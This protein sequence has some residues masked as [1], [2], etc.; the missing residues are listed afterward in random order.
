MSRA[1]S[2]N[3]LRHNK[4]GDMISEINTLLDYHSTNFESLATS[5]SMLIENVNMQMESEVADLV[6]RR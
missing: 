3:D 5:I 4:A 6:D 2:D 1:K